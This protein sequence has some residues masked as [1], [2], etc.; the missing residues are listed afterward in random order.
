MLVCGVWQEKVQLLKQLSSALKVQQTHPV[1]WEKRRRFHL[2]T[3]YSQYHQLYSLLCKLTIFPP[4]K[5]IK[6]MS[7]SSQHILWLTSIDWEGPVILVPPTRCRVLG[8]RE[9]TN[10]I[11][12]LCGGGVRVKWI[13]GIHLWLEFSARS[14][15]NC[16][17]FCLL[18][19]LCSEVWNHVLLFQHFLL[20]LPIFILI[21]TFSLLVI[22]LAILIL[23][24]SVFTTVFGCGSSGC[25]GSFGGLRPSTGVACRGGI[26]G[27]CYAR[28]DGARKGSDDTATEAQTGQ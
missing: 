7:V 16:I 18:F 17:L 26:A 23:F 2:W 15:V 14:W 4:L 11:S 20:F 27:W 25:R 9:C 10:F 8:D 3:T 13:M 21:S 28:P 24:I 22:S 19:V 6:T 12:C 5:R 1:M